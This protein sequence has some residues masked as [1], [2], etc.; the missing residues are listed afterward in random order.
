MAQYITYKCEKCGYEVSTNPCGFDA[1]MTGMLVN[2][3]CDHCK[4]IVFISPKQMDDYCII[5]PK[6]GEEVS[7]TWNPVEGSCPRC[8]GHMEETG[9]IIMAD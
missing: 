7:A 4:E 6:C 2:F 5:C 3:R 9:E 1:I 8:G